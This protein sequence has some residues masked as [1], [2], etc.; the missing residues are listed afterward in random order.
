MGWREKML[1]TCGPGLL[2]G[3]TLGHWLRLLRQ[4]RWS[5]DGRGLPRALTITLLGLKNS[6]LS[7]SEQRRFGPLIKEVEVPPPIFVLGHWRQG[8]THLHQLLAQDRRFAFPNNFQVSFPHVFLSTEA[9]D[10]KRI[11]F[12][13]P[14][15]RPMDNVQWTLASPQEDEFAL[16]ILT[17][18]SPCMG[19]IFPR[20]RERFQK[21]LTFRDV[22]A[23]E[24]AQWQA[25][26]L[27][28]LKKLTWKYRKPLLLKSPP[29]TARIRLLL[30]LFPG[31]KF[32]HI[33]RNPYD[34]FL[35]TRKTLQSMLVWQTLQRRPDPEE[36][37]AW[38]LRQYRELYDAFFEE[39]ALV[40]RGCFHEL[41]FEDL[42]RDPVGEVARLYQ[43]LGLPGFEEVESGLRRYVHSLTG[44]NKNVF[45]EPPPRLKARIAREWERT[46][47]GW[48]YRC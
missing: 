18:K 40:P 32:V 12:F 43:A 20:Q 27:H 41:R 15:H 30:E 48:G 25:A 21:Y 38:V 37:D 16:C 39:K 42:E 26:F 4:Q 36:V 5:V 47:A 6:V 8:T 34:V 22:S 1:T 29:H 11:E 13:L 3:V 31:A 9:R 2:G 46:F 17:F 44:Y 45:P 33:Q 35:S 10:S 23:D 7:L 19:W 24:I 28:F 14:R